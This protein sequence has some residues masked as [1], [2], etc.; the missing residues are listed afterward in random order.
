MAVC[1]KEV[2]VQRSKV[3]RDVANPVSTVYE[4]KHTVRSAK[5]RKPFE[6]HPNARQSSDGVEDSHLRFLPARS[7]LAE[8]GFEQLAQLIIGDGIGILD[9]AGLRRRRLPNIAYGFLT[10]AIDRGEVDN[11]ILRSKD[12]IPKDGVDASSCIRYEHAGFHRGI[13]VLGDGLSRS[14]DMLW[15]LVANGCIWSCFGF[16]LEVLLYTSDFYW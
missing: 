15:V 1:N 16:G 7:Y 4:R 10:R 2:R 12:Q 3:E 13:Q 5:I 14:I 6:G 11:H 8:G 9:P